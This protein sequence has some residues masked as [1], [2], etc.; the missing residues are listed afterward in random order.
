MIL[1][2]KICFRAKED[3]WAEEICDEMEGLDIE[4]P[5]LLSALIIPI[6]KPKAK[7]Q[8]IIF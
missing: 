6:E 8:D 7:R 2:K 3:T 4:Q 1:D 5:I